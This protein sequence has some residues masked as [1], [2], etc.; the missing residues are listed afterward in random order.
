[1]NGQTWHL[2]VQPCVNEAKN[3]LSRHAVFGIWG[4][5][6]CSQ[7][8]AGGCKPSTL[9]TFSLSTSKKGSISTLLPHVPSI[10]ALSAFPTVLPGKSLYSTQPESPSVLFASLRYWLHLLGWYPGFWIFFQL[11]WL[12]FKYLEKI[13]HL[14]Q[15]CKLWN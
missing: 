13:F 15:E 2:L 11:F 9:L 4:L 6:S 5:F 14:S 3:F 7:C 10:Q 12:L 1:M 8:S